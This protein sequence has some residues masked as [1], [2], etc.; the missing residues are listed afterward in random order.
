[1]LFLLAPLEK[2]SNDVGIEAIDENSRIQND[3]WKQVLWLVSRLSI[4]LNQLILCSGQ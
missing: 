1:M 3:L 4:K 2:T